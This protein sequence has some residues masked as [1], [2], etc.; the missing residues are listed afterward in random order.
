MRTVSFQGAQLTAGQR[1]NQ[2]FQQQVRS[3]FLSVH[4]QQ[5]VEQTIA[6]VEQ[7]KEQGAKKEKVWFKDRE[8][9]GTPCFCELFGY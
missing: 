1:R 6:A 2:A 3:S 9:F 4:L 5:Q 8:E 7:R